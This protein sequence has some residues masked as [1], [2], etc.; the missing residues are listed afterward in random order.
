LQLASQAAQSSDARVDRLIA[1]IDEVR[2]EES[3]DTKF[4]I[5]T[6]FLPTQAMLARVL[7]GY[8]YRVSVLNGQMNMDE[9]IVV[10]EAFR[11]ASQFLISTDAGGEG[12][13]LQFAHIVVNYD[14]PWN[15]MRIEQRIGRVD[16]IGQRHVVRAFNF[17]IAD[18]V[19][20]RVH[21]VLL[22]K[23][24]RILEELG[25]DK[26]GDVLDSTGLDVDY[27]GLYLSALMDPERAD[28]DLTRWVETVRN[29]ADQSIKLNSSI[30]AGPP[31]PGRLKTILHHPLPSWMA[32]MVENYVTAR[33]GTIQRTTLGWTITFPDGVVMQDA[34]FRPDSEDVGQTYLA[35]DHPEIQQMLESLPHEVQGSPLARLVSEGFPKGLRGLWSLWQ[36]TLRYGEEKD[37]RILP[38]FL[39]EDGRVF[40]AS[41]VQIWEQLT[42]PSFKGNLL[43]SAQKL[44]DRTWEKLF[45]RAQKEAEPLYHELK[46]AHGVRIRDERT[47][48]EQ[49]FKVR[50]EII[51][52]VG[53]ANVREARL[54]RLES[55]YAKRLQKMADTSAMSPELQ[56]LLVLEVDAS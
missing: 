15:P 2:R 13:N 53:L 39:S 37:R 12:L 50:R 51:E 48:M 38:L 44:D 9:R 21:E 54:R 56:P 32:S 24:H 40:R 55:E 18:T 6:E 10:Q 22:E 3:S 52:R 14:L 8:G 34:I 30:E 25:I 33:G 28:S 45:E 20:Y 49:A 5:F 16:R 42:H 17:V 19:E 1:L 26:L 29:T 41:S 11:H 27:Q 35:L 46:A 4:L 31:D 47:A 7:T 36:L 23:L 43:P